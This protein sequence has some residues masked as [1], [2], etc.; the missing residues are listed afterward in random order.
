[1]DKYVTRKRRV[2][3]SRLDPSCHSGDSSED[4]A[5]KIKKIPA[6]FQQSIRKIKSSNF[7]C[8]YGILYSPEEAWAI[9]QKCESLVEYL[10]GPCSKVQVFG[11]WHN[12]P[13]KHVAYGDTGLSYKFSGNTVN[14]KPWLPFLEEVKLKVES[15]C[16]S[17]FNFVLINRYANG[18][19]HMGEH[20]DDEKELVKDSPIASLS[21]GQPRDF[22]FR[23]Q[24][25]RN[26]SIQKDSYESPIKIS[27]ENGSV[28]V[29]NP[30]TNDF[31]YHSLPKRSLKSCPNVRINFTFR[32]MHVLR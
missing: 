25:L 6:A 13:R 22:V 10:A 2:L 17:K 11:K 4:R 7:D 20:K 28:L 24:D 1:M 19:D 5:T 18:F 32:N 3:E 12:V 21:V 30:P 23:H 9:M 15:F 27:L 31:W 14:A 8:D 26:K 29:M 16:N